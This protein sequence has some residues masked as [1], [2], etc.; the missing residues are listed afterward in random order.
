MLLLARIPL[1]GEGI[2]IIIHAVIFTASLSSAFLLAGD[3][4]TLLPNG[5]VRFC[6]VISLG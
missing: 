5:L 4:L 6:T 2:G 1:I 3:N